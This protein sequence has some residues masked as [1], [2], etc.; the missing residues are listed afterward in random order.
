MATYAGLYPLFQ[1]AYEE[2]GYPGRYFNDRLIEVI[3]HLLAAPEIPG[4]VKVKRVE[5]KGG[6]SNSQ[7]PGGLYQ[8]A[9]PGLEARSAG[10]KIMLRIGRQNAAALKGK[11]QELREEVVAAGSTRKRRKR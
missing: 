7:R 11:L 2:L 5:A 6:S 9:D 1:E 4:P 10:Q 8:F 3:D